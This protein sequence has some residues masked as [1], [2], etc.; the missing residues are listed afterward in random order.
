M[1]Q[2]ITPSTTWLNIRESIQS[3]TEA[4]LEQCAR[5]FRILQEKKGWQT[6]PVYWK[7]RSELNRN[8]K[9]KRARGTL[10]TLLKETF[11]RMKAL[12]LTMFEDDWIEWKHCWAVS[13]LYPAILAFTGLLPSNWCSSCFSSLCWWCWKNNSLKTSRG[14]YSDE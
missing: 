4:L 14:S 5:W 8:G 9:M 13:R 2:S 10:T 3:R 12:Q 7:E 1:N 11:N 6:L